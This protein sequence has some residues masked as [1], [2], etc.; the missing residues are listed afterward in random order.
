MIRS[1]LIIASMWLAAAAFAAEASKQPPV[2][3]SQPI[4]DFDGKQERQCVE[5]KPIPNQNEC[6]K[7]IDLTV[8]ILASRAL[9][10]RAKEDADIR[11]DDLARRGFLSIKIYQNKPVALSSDDQTLIKK[12]MLSYGTWPGG[13]PISSFMYAQACQAIDPTCGGQ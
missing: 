6:A 5:A 13:L 12:L 7:Y 4:L 1:A 3:F 8:G 2:D 9:Q 11:P 10:P